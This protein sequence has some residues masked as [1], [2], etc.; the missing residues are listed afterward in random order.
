MCGRY[1]IAVEPTEIEERFGAEFVETAE[2][3]RPRY[4]AAPSQRLPVILNAEPDKILL[5][6]ISILSLL[7]PKNLCLPPCRVKGKSLRLL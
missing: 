2:P 4:N 5:T 7:S 1:S 3:T 6:G